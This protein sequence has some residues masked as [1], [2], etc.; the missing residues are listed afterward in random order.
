M[1]RSTLSC[2]TAAR[3]RSSVGRG[4]PCGQNAQPK[5]ECHRRCAQHHE[6]RGGGGLVLT[7]GLVLCLYGAPPAR[8]LRR[9]L[10]A[11]RGSSPLPSAGTRQRDRKAESHGE[12]KA[13]QQ[14]G[15]CDTTARR[16]A[17][18]RRRPPGGAD[19]HRST[20]VGYAHST[21][22]TRPREAAQHSPSSTGQAI[23][24]TLRPAE[25]PGW[26][27]RLPS[28][29]H[30]TDRLAPSRP[31]V[32]RTSRRTRA[33]Q[34]P[35]RRAHARQAGRGGAGR[36]AA[37]KDDRPHLR[38]RRHLALPLSA[39]GLTRNERERGLLLERAEPRCSS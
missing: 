30:P 37:T 36:G 10:L 14:C 26:S 27:Q 2:R 31:T 33:M 38:G 39:A 7:A 15:P 35:G 13:P 23:A 20:Q 1:C 8:W 22:G 6:A 17:S 18:R 21:Q 11:A 3:N 19:N 34:A 12:Q 28:M 32:G 25:L 24:M 9:Y 29:P 5:S 16:A 4:W